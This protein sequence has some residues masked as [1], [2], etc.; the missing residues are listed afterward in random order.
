[1]LCAER[2]K[3]SYKLIFVLVYVAD[4]IGYLVYCES[5]L[6]SGNEFSGSDL[7]GLCSASVFHS[8]MKFIEDFFLYHSGSWTDHCRKFIS[9]NQIT[10]SNIRIT[11]I[12]FCAFA[13]LMPY[14]VADLRLWKRG[15]VFS[16]CRML[17]D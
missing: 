2:Q 14:I 11:N 6:D 5:K 13:Y 10:F 12:Y 4:W 8:I 3:R 17:I 7:P 9:Q 16:S 15:N 1:M